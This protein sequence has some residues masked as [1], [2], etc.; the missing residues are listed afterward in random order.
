MNIK[1]ITILKFMTEI[2]S[3]SNDVDNALKVQILISQLIKADGYEN[4][5]EVSEK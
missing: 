1:Q 5:R 4:V 2:L 3:Q